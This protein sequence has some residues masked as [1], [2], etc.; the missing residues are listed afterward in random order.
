M[1]PTSTRALAR[2]GDLSPLATNRAYGCWSERDM[3]VNGIGKRTQIFPVLNNP[4][5]T[6]QT[7]RNPQSR[8]PAPITNITTLARNTLNP[9]TAHQTSPHSAAS[10]LNPSTAH[11]SSPH[12]AASTLNPSTAHQSSP[13]SAASTLNP[14]T[15]HQSL[16][17]STAIPSYESLLYSPHLIHSRKDN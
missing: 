10:T 14:S 12:S 9:S 17:H 16:P 1:S 11:Q 3:W 7:P 2:E 6:H 15:A 13:H 8:E 5:M 4:G